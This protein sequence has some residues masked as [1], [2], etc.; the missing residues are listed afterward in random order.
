MQSESMFNKLVKWVV[1]IAL[2]YMVY[3]MFFAGSGEKIDLA[4]YV[5]ATADGLAVS[6]GVDLPDNPDM[7]SKI[8]QYSDSKIKVRGN[9]HVGVVYFDGKQTGLFCDT[10]SYSFFNVKLGD[11]MTSV[12][13]NMTYEY[14]DVFYVINEYGGMSTTYFYYNK[15]N[16]DC[17]AI[18]YNT[19]HDKVAAMTYYNDYRKISENLSVIN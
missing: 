19:Q 11:Y 17:F 10:R 8:H 14:D 5:D 4:N 15:A 6:L 3:T 16:N 13:A 9:G 1:V 12:E 18:I 2:V 7:V